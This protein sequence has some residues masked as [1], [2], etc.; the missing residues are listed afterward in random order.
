MSRSPARGRREASL[1]DVAQVAGVSA[2][3]VSRVAMGK[4]QVRPET[5]ER[6]IEAMRELGY[7][8]NG[9]ARALKYGRFRTIGVI[10]FTLA[11]YG[12]M[13][14]LGAISDEATRAGYSLTLISLEAATQASVSGAFAQLSEQAVDGVVLV[15]PADI[16]RGRGVMIPPGLPVVVI[17]SSPDETHPFVDHDQAQGARLATE[18]LLDLGH[19]TV[20]HVAGPTGSWS[21]KRRRESWADVLAERGCELLEP[22]VGD[23]SADSGWAAGQRLAELPQVTA[24]FAANDQ[25]ALGLMRAL[26]EAGRS[27]PAEISVVGFD[28]T[29]D[30]GN[31]WPPL[32]TVHQ[33]FELVGREALQALVGQIEQQ[34]VAELPLVATELVLRAS[35]APPPKLP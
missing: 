22:F 29:P 25:M 16:A 35:T 2:Q 9:A 10:M 17:D 34:P 15:V 30:S 14:T 32:T 3:T 6:V 1:A 26:H 20:W 12:N 24:V 33:H 31:Y 13:R 27:V 18:H 5:R 28:D 23:W 11:T 7:R 19:R 21:A 4:E 8:P